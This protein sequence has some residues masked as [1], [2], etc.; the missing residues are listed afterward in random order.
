MSFANACKKPKYFAAC[1]YFHVDS[2]HYIEYSFCNYIYVM[3]IFIL[4]AHSIYFMN[5]LFYKRD[6]F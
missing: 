5:G 3:N 4:N 1:Y 6:M 2:C